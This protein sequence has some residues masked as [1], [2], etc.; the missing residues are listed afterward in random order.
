MPAEKRELVDYA[1]TQHKCSLRQACLL[2]S[3]STSVY[4]YKAKRNPQ[5]DLI[6]QELQTLADRH[7]GWGFW[8][9]F[10]YLRL[11]SY[12]WNHKRVYR[13][14]TQMKLNL[15]RKYK[16]RIPSRIKQ[17]LVQPLYPNMHWSMD[18]MSDSLFVGR[19]FRSFNVI[20]DYNR[21]ALNI[22]LD[23][24]LPSVRVIREL[25]QLI[26]WRGKPEQ[27]RVDNGPEFIAAKMSAWC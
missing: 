27:I 17:P 22:T 23:T 13:V 14:Y 24:S 19:P 2:F 16:Q 9:M 6:E 18:F 20:D 5:D 26:E 7:R 4:Y 3:L 21:E 12:N 8:M 1:R 11:N 10:H 15:R 25:E